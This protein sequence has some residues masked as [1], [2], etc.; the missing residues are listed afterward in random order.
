MNLA[1][2]RLKPLDHSLS[3]DERALRRCDTAADLILAGQY[4][5]AR[6][7]LSGFWCG[8]GARPNVEGLADATAAEVLLQCGALSGWLG[9]SK[10]ATSSQEAAKDLIS[11]SVSLLER[12]NEAGRAALARSDLALCYW[13]EGAYDNAR[14]L[15]T[16]ALEKATEG[17]GRAKILLWLKEKYIEMALEEAGGSVTTAARLLGIGHQSLTSL[18]ETRHG[19]LLKKRKP[20]KKRRRSII[21]KKR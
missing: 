10:Q 11:E 21:R 3:P 9:T 13:R 2:D 8:I 15:L 7:A 20:A 5:A 4:E 19:R 17:E 18:I 6:A 14:A 12:L 16:D 1:D